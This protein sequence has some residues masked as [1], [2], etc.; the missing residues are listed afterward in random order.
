MSLPGFLLT[1]ETEYVW[2]WVQVQYNPYEWRHHHFKALQ[3]LTRHR[4]NGSDGT[5]IKGS[6]GTRKHLHKHKHCSRF[7]C[8]INTCSSTNPTCWA[9][10]SFMRHC[11]Y[12]KRHANSQYK[13]L[14]MPSFLGIIHY[15]SSCVVGC[16]EKLISSV[17][18]IVGM[19]VWSSTYMCTEIRG[20]CL[21]HSQ[22]DCWICHSIPAGHHEPA[23]E[24]CSTWESLCWGG[25][26]SLSQV[27]EWWF[28]SLCLLRS[29][30]MC[31]IL[32]QSDDSLCGADTQ[33][34]PWR[35]VEHIL[36]SKWYTDMHCVILLVC[37][38]V[39]L[40]WQ[41]AINKTMLYRYPPGTLLLCLSCNLDDC[42]LL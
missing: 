2:Y 9:I 37:F 10:G 21:G 1:S 36:E 30:Q 17:V 31:H 14:T 12:I 28:L 13:Y 8:D 18:V 6:L 23:A 41:H 16:L 11:R 38:V 33:C 22:C 19:I 25:G 24:A 32:V 3:K 34:S 27:R 29:A 40:L 5:L 15:S 4:R 42:I 26:W 39:C 7:C 35:G 20:C